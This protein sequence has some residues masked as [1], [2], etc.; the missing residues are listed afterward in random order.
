MSEPLQAHTA[1]F[2][3]VKLAREQAQKSRDLRAQIRDSEDERERMRFASEAMNASMIATEVLSQAV[4]L[5]CNM[6]AVGITATVTPVEAEAPPAVF[7][8]TIVA[9]PDE[10]A[11]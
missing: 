5:A 11:V 7:T 6:W 8:P 1:L 4:E 2:Q 3:M 9:A 10:A